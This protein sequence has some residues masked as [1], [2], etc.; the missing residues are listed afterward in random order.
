MLPN[1]QLSM[2]K[3]SD[4]NRREHSNSKKKGKLISC[5]LL[6]TILLARKTQVNQTD[7]LKAITLMYNLFS[8][9]Y[10]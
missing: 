6:K 1:R 5:V 10:H 7:S 4:N 2:L 8:I 9:Y 3:R